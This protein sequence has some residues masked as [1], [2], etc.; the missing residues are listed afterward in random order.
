VRPFLLAPLNGAAGRDDRR[1]TRAYPYTSLILQAGRPYGAPPGRASGR[2]KDG[3]E[4]HPFHLSLHLRSPHINQVQPGRR[5]TS[6]A[7]RERSTATST[8][9]AAARPRPTRLFAIDAGM[10]PLFAVF[11]S[12]GRR[13]CFSLRPIVSPCLCVVRPCCWFVTFSSPPPMLDLDPA[14][15]L[16]SQAY[17]DSHHRLKTNICTP[18]TTSNLPLID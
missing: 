2:G 1:V 8:R 4:L 9:S 18:S 13:R 5:D 15:L 12:N 3:G 16:W 7:D 14:A 6:T 17:T 10:S 11:T